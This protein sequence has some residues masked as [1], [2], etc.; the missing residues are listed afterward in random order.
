[1]ADHR[2]HLAA[3]HVGP[4]R[5]AQ[6]GQAAGPPSYLPADDQRVIATTS[7]IGGGEEVSVTF[8]MAGLEVGGDYTFFCSF[9]GHSSLMRGTVVVTP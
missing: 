3:E 1:M 5:F 4:L 6:A 2:P 7:V 8:D 9:P